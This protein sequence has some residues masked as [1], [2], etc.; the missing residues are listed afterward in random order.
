MTLLTQLFSNAYTKHLESEFLKRMKIISEPQNYS[1]TIHNYASLIESLG[2]LF[3]EF[4]RQTLVNIFQEIDQKFKQSEIRK[5]DYYVKDFRERTLVTPYEV[6]TFK[7]T[8]YQNKIDGKCFTY[9]DRKLGLPRWDTYDPCS[10]RLKLI[11]LGR[12]MIKS[13]QGKHHEEICQRT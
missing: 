8:L 10:S 4:C 3:Q 12:E 11:H 6:I 9:L 7:R 2:D 1:F 5:R 13:N